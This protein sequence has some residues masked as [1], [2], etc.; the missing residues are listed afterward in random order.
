MKTY[1]L[2]MDFLCPVH[3]GTGEDIDPF[4]FTIKGN[5]L[6]LVDMERWLVDESENQ[7]LLDK[8]TQLDF[9]KLRNFV[10]KNI[11]VDRYAKARIPVK[12]S[13]LVNDYKNAVL[14]GKNPLNQ[15]LLNL[16]PRS[17]A[18][19]RPFI[20]GSSIKGSMR[21]A[22]GS[23]V[24]QHVGV[25]KNDR[26]LEYNKKIFG[27]IRED[28]FRH[29]KVS[30]APLSGLRTSIVSGDEVSKNMNRKAGTPK[31]HFEVTPS[32]CWAEGPYTVK[33]K[34]MWEDFKLPSLTGT[35]TL[36]VMIKALNEFY[37]PKYMKELKDFY[38]LPH[39][40]MVGR[41]L[42]KVTSIVNSINQQKPE[43]NALMRIGHFSHLECMTFD[44]MRNPR[45]KYG[46]TRTLANKEI[47]FG[48]VKISFEQGYEPQEL[49]DAEYVTT[50]REVPSGHKPSTARTKEEITEDRLNSLIMQLDNMQ[51]SKMPGMLP[52]LARNIL[53]S[54]DTAYRQKA[55]QIVLERIKNRGMKKKFKAKDWFKELKKLNQQ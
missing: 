38:S 35:I 36:D 40:N 53:S 42:D 50:V 49:S 18:S 44:R 4:Y 23:I 21:T 11:P 16:L 28:R 51:T 39:L 43:G 10:A 9:V 26:I 54:E 29:V 30:D 34:F 52:Q 31:G 32:L 2:T 55:S 3:I 27:D 1:T 12:S 37:I 7:D 19:G 5:E 41:K 25:K 8:F 20:P 48:W 13:K 6:I 22:L 47:P 14:Q 46:T 33:S 45:G 24:A 15:V 17:S